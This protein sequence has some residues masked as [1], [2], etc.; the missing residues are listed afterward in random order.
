MKI[1]QR[2]YEYIEKKGLKPAEF[3]RLTGISNGYVSK[4]HRRLSDVG[5]GIILQVV[6][7]CPEI[8]PLWLVFGEGDMLRK[9][10]GT[11]QPLTGVSDIKDV[12]DLATQ[13]GMQIKENEQLHAKNMELLAQLEKVKEKKE[14]KMP[15]VSSKE[16]ENK[17][18][19]IQNFAAEPTEEHKI[20]QDE[21]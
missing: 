20:S 17:N 2:I 8:S 5:E 15:S 10:L 18:I 16:Y 4:M 9:E 12:I 21:Y 6:E 11:Y 3:E 1:I 13:L 19:G 7:N 14:K